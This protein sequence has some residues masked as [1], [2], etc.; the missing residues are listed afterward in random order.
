MP[1]RRVSVA[2][3]LLAALSA[4]AAEEHQGRIALF[5]DQAFRRGFALSYPSSAMG[6]RVEKVLETE[7]GGAP[8]WRLCQWA[9]RLSLAD[10]PLRRLP[11]NELSWENETK[12]VVLGN[13]AAEKPDL[14]LEVRG[15]AEYQGRVRRAGEPWPHLLVEQDALAV[16]PLDRPASLELEVEL[17]LSR[18]EDRM[19]GRADA[20]LHA[21]QFQLFFVVKETAPGADGDFFWFGV[22]FFDSR[23]E[24]PAAYRAKDG[25]KD[26]AT[27]KFIYTIDGR[28]ALPAPPR[29]G[30]W[31]KVRKDLLPSIAAGLAC[32]V[33]R[34]FL[35]NGELARYAVVNMNMGWELPGAYDAAVEVRGLSVAAVLR[36]GADCPRGARAPDAARPAVTSGAGGPRSRR[37][38]RTSSPR[39][40]T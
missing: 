17:K 33:E 20:S 36:P 27:G 3:A 2:A 14:I 5:A 22:P 25:G 19:A 23:G 34:G 21:A 26:D 10:A 13:G 28:E 4:A 9:T 40:C 7:S 35:A 31:V 1:G 8:A 29:L 18:F 39:A 37:G 24:Y 30:Q 38:A 12:R 32:A 6:R 15:G 11:G 16:V